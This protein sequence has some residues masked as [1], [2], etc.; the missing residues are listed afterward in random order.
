MT[1]LILV[2]AYPSI[3]NLYTM[4]FVHSRCLMYNKMNINIE[5]LSFS[6]K[7]NYTFEGISIYT[8]KDYVI[9]TRNVDLIISHAP[10]LKNHIRL[11][12]TK[13]YRNY[14][15]IIFFHG[16]EIMETNKYYPKAFKFDLTN[17]SK[18]LISLIYDP[19]KLLIIKKFLL[20]RLKQ[21]NIKLVF[22]S[23]WMMKVAFAS[24]K[25]KYNDRS[26]LKKISSVIFNGVNNVFLTKKY[27]FNIKNK[28]DFIT[29]RP[30][31]DSK[32]GIDIVYK[33]AQDN[34]EYSFHVYGKGD[35][36]NNVN[37]LPNLK[38]FNKFIL[39]NEIPD[40]LNKY[41]YAL[42]PTR[43]DAQGVMMC[44]IAT[45]GMPLVTSDIEIC[46]E[47]LKE[48]KNVSFISNNLN[49]KISIDSSIVHLKENNLLS[50]NNEKFN[51]YILAKKEVDLI[52]DLCEQKEL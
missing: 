32:Y 38:I 19:I 49:K 20:H 29:I 24:M 35:F 13:N 31:D 28:A 17:R 26:R 6:A 41:K 27:H 8:E 23:A 37:A 46:R 39:Q 21:N 45:F 36:F 11:L 4:A 51:G 14:P 18:R 12:L 30:F 34:P 9:A 43:L 40:L 42:M 44:E 16:H 2:E 22:V 15:L 3:E 48:F 33:I 47:M 50:L 10:N 1:V 52:I 25:L 7:K 5:I